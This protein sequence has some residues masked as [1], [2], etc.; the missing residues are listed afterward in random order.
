MG[1]HAANI[2]RPRRENQ[3]DGC[4]HSPRL[5]RCLCNVALSCGAHVG[6]GTLRS[7]LAWP[8]QHEFT[9][10]QAVLMRS[11]ARGAQVT[12]FKHGVRNLDGE[13]QAADPAFAA[14][15]LVARKLPPRPLRPRLSTTKGVRAHCLRPRL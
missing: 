10:A 8:A 5:W 13:E 4:T 1:L 12:Q 3:R 9:N 2:A 6:E 14:T 15:R 11:L 7:P